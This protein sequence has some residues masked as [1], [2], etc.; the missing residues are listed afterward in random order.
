M[1]TRCPQCKTVHPLNAE[2]V[3]RA[4]GL[5]QCGQCGRA[6]SALSFLFDDWPSGQ[7][8]EPAKG[9]N[10][11]L[12][13]LGRVTKATGTA[14]SLPSESGLT[15]ESQRKPRQLAWRLAMA[16]LVLLTIVNM[17]WTFREPLM[18]NPAISASMKQAGWFQIEPDGPL[19]NL[20]Q[21]QL[22]SRDMH[23]HP[24]RSGVLVL[25]LTFVN[26]AQRSQAFPGLEVTLLDT[27]NQ[28]VARR[29]LQPADYLRAGANTKAGLAADV[30][31][32]VLLELADP[33]QKAVGFEIRFL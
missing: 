24:T 2:L 12:P 31:L 20:Q 6:F 16:L 14:S 10:A 33:G 28:P 23:V 11:S 21:M 29:R 8:H 3:S 1:F 19:R 22:V 9:A 30:Y 25:N 17:A 18:V 7:A 26:L 27:T 4:R 32:P 13:V 15:D 5:V